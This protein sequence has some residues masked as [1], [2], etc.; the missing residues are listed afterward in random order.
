MYTT[1]ILSCIIHKSAHLLEGPTEIC[2]GDDIALT[3]VVDS[4]VTTWNVSYAG[5]N[6]ACQYERA[7]QVPDTCGPDGRFRS[8]QTEGSADD[9]N[10]SLTV[11]SVSEDLNGTLV[12]CTNGDNGTVTGYYDICITGK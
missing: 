8:A 3:C 5:E 11:V 4:P 7:S 9:T 2:P 1:A 6:D 10:S 12:K